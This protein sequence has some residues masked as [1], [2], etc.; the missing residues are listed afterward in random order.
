MSSQDNPSCHNPCGPLPKNTAQHELLYSQIENFTLNFFGDVVK[1]EIDGNTSWSL[2]CRLDIGLP[3]NP[4]GPTEPLGCYFLRLFN[5][6]TGL[7]GEDGAPGFNGHDGR[8]AY[9]SGGADVIGPAGPRGPVGNTGPQG[10]QGK[11]GSPGAASTWFTT[12]NAAGFTGVD[13]IGSTYAMTGSYT[14]VTITT[15][16]QVTL[17]ATGTYF[18]YYSVSPYFGSILGVGIANL[19]MNWK[20]TNSTQAVDIAGSNTFLENFPV[21]AG[22]SGQFSSISWGGIFTGNAGDQVGVYGQS[23]QA[24]AGNTISVVW[25]GLTVVRIA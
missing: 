6:V 25:A 7:Q 13:S 12:S 24:G 10:P 5:G 11:T 2:P 9:I 8:V 18:A 22:T 14:L 21:T 20:L 23:P 16:A 15:P 1:T 19:V 3:S 17:P 4:R